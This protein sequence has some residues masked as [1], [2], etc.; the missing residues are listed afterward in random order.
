MF[1][2]KE[3]VDNDQFIN[4]VNAIKQPSL[5]KLMESDPSLKEMMKTHS[6]L[7]FKMQPV[8]DIHLKSHLEG[9]FESNTTSLHVSLAFLFGIAIF[10]ITALNFVNLTTSHVQ[11]KMHE[12][13]ENADGCQS[14][15][16]THVFG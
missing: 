13:G 6:R 16:H 11:T 10:L 5:V 1:V 8:R 2:L 3:G 7:D 12:V 14:F 4:K 15:A 9:E